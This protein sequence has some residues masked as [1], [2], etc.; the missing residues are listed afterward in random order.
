MNWR[1][2]KTLPWTFIPFLML[3]AVFIGEVLPV[4]IGIFGGVF[5]TYGAKEPI[6]KSW[7]DF[8]V[9]LIIYTVLGFFF[10][11]L[12]HYISWRIVALFAFVL[13]FSLEKWLYGHPEGEIGVTN[14]I[15]FGTIIQFV[16]VYFLVLVLPYLIFQG[17]RRKWNRRGIAAYFSIVIILITLGLGFTYYTM[18]KRGLWPWRPVTSQNQSGGQNNSNFAPMLPANTCPDKLVERKDQPTLAYQ[19]GVAMLVPQDVDQWVRANCPGV[20]QNG[21]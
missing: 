2:D 11:L 7:P 3:T 19:N 4:V 18:V 16:V 13:A 1:G 8:G 5:A 12:Y 15:S 9:V 14:T 6:I 17:I 21:E 10:W 20:L